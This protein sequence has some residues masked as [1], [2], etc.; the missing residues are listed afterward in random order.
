M[1][2][3]SRSGTAYFERNSTHLAELERRYEDEEQSNYA[4]R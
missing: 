4:D 3:L 1:I 2:E